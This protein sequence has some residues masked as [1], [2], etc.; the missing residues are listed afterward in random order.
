VNIPVPKQKEEK[1]RPEFLVKSG[2]G[3]TT[4]GGEGKKVDENTGSG[5]RDIRERKFKWHLTRKKK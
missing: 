4:M 3:E 5:S 1:I 2:D